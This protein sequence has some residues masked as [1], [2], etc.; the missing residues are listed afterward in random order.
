MSIT[1]DPRSLVGRR[2]RDSRRL[3]LGE[4]EVAFGSEDPAEATYVGLTAPQGFVVVPLDGAE[5]HDDAVDLPIRGDLIAAAPTMDRDVD[6]DPALEER[7]RAHFAR[8]AAAVVLSEERL[9]VDVRRVP[10]ERVRL[11]KEVVEETVNVP[12]TIRRE[13]LVVDRAPFDA[14]SGP[15]GGPQSAAAP[16][17]PEDDVEWVLWAEEPVVTT[18]AVPVERVRLRKKVV[19]DEVVVSETLR[20]EHAA[21]DRDGSA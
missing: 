13:R 20:T 9:N 4:I 16:F 12:V 2:A 18:R 21:V 14:S 11:R 17:S 10:A 19:Q 1:I 15:A 5:L 7:I 8:E 3:D 6:L